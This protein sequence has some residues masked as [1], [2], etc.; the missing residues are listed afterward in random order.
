MDSPLKILVIE[1]VPADFL[2]V[3]RCLSQHGL[4]A[5]CRHI[6]SDAELEAALQTEWDLVLSDY[7]VPGMDFRA[8]LQRI[9]ARWPTLPV[10]MVSGSVGEETAVELLRLGLKDFILKDHLVR[11]PTAV[12]RAVDE[13][14]DHC[15]RLAAEAALREGQA[16]A[17][18]VQRQARLAA[19]NLMEDAVAAR[20]RA[21]A[22]LAD[23]Q[24]SRQSLRLLLDS[25]AEGAYG[26]DTRGNC[27]FV[28]RA[29]L[30]MLGYANAD[31]VLGKHIHE[32]VHHS[33]PDGSAYPSGEC[34][35]YR[36]Y[37]AG[38]ATHIADEVFW[39]KDGT[40]IPVEYWSSPILSN[41]EVT[42]A[43]CTFIDITE[44]RK[45]EA[46]LVLDASR[47]EALLVLPDAAEAMDERAFMRYGQ[48]L[49]EQLSDS[50]IAFIHFV[51]EDQKALQLVA[52]TCISPE[53]ACRDD[54]DGNCPI[55]QAGPWAEALRQRTPVVF[56]DCVA[57][58][59]KPGLPAD[60]PQLR[61][62]ISVPVT[63]GGLVRMIVS[64]G[65]KP[66]PYT[67]LD[68]ETVRLLANAIW[69]IV[70]QRRADTALRESEERLSVA[71]EATQIG[72]WDW[73]I[74]RDLWYASPTY[75][76]MLGYEPEAG[77]ADRAVWLD[78]IHPDDRQNVAEKI[79]RIQGGGDGPYQYEARMRRADGSWRWV[80]V[81][82]K[83]VERDENGRATRMRGV[84]MDITERK[85]TEEQLRKL[86]QAVEQSPESIVITN[87][88]AE[89]EYVNEAFI[90]ATGYGREEVIGRNPRML[91]SGKTPK[92]T[93]AAMWEALSQGRPWKGEFHNK[94][95][96]GS[97][98]IEFAIITQLRRPDGSV[99]HYVAVKEDITEKKRLG[100]ELDRHRHHL[101]LLV[102]SRTTELV[103]AR[104]QAEAANL[105]KSSFL[106]NMSHEIR[107]PLNAIIGLTHLL[108]RAGATPQQAVR[109]DKVDG[110]GQHLLAIINDILDLSKIE[111]GR[112]QLERTDFHLS[113]VLDNV[114]SIISQSARDKGLRIELDRDAVP[115]WLKGDATRLRQ[116][117]L[118]YAGNAVKFTERGTITLRAL[119]LH[120]RGDEILVR[121]EV[122]DTG[123]GI[124]PEQMVRLFRPF[125]QADASITRKYGGTGLGLV[126]VRRLAQM[127]GGEV[128]ADSTPGT[129]SCFWFTARLQRGHGIMPT[130][131]P[132]TDMERAETQLRRHHSGARLLLAE[133]NPINREVAL[134]LLH[135]AGLAVDTAVDGREAV[136]KARATAYDLILMD[137]QMPDM[138]GLEATRAIRALPGWETKPILAMTA[139]AF[140]E[141]RH[142]CETAGM[143][144]FITKPVDPGA[145]YKTLLLWLSVAT[146]GM[147]D[148][149]AADAAR[150]ALAT[151]PTAAG[152]GQSLPQPL[153]D[154]DGLDVAQGLAALRG[155]A[156]AY[157]G[158]LRHLA[159][160]HREDA[161]HLRDELAAGRID[162]ARQRAHALKGAAGSL[163]VTRL[164]AAAAAIERTLRDAAP[165]APALLDAL[166]NEQ[167][168]LDEVLARL[169]G[170]ATD[171]GGTQVAADLGRARAVLRQMEPL[172]A[173]D[174]TAAGDL[175]EA[176]R[177]LLQ[178]TL[179]SAALQLERQLANFDYPAALTTLRDM[180]RQAP[181]N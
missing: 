69:R 4:A 66:K 17:F 65:N 115:P 3:E 171:G 86:A 118:N 81:L 164:Q 10:V 25:M 61:R 85:T 63:E 120:E 132:A 19:L 176:N 169:P 99:S 23:L 146:A 114:A 123:L 125:E 179:G 49:V 78:R 128:G 27:S 91:H 36:A 100:V 41:G 32:L 107:T 165:I 159:E 7:S 20:I 109:L 14:R 126:I 104:R 82:G 6:A 62:L 105:A 56:N 167:L 170:P 150:F 38:Q 168:A 117:L 24:D 145:L 11:L 157:L 42:G 148:A 161:Q 50:G 163:G 139:N 5:E 138:D 74:E 149:P 96:D 177:P 111:A 64:A 181:E 103:A 30:E 84:R 156:A 15:A 166:Q 106:A 18:E 98:Y 83:A 51:S 1:D 95:K 158:L 154:F 39:R 54:F 33:R 89:I 92:E 2:L 127:M 147:G 155:D 134:E 94:R 46:S 31:E 79:G 175:F 151:P 80:A 26:T 73:D 152:G 71:L 130:E 180:I 37:I 16:A 116:A 58:A 113:A 121:F 133:D 144:D 110:A 172:L 136:E 90:A 162:A 122:E 53:L 124:S 142:A 88:D 75:F 174:D 45:N 112:L 102:E 40:A 153:A 129:G 173:H 70:R 67:D 93:H 57:A 119:L 34:K 8:T 140:D 28:N 135:G 76:T 22:A 97:E 178:A 43:I 48:E 143:N 68:M 77:P 87:V 12:R 9:Q 13:A 44:R 52:C 137:M 55:S 108:R 131:S 21:E 160:G 72:I 60:F 35:M 141:D 29:F 59:D 101:E 47:A